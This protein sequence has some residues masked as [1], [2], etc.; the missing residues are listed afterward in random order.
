MVRHVL[1]RIRIAVEQVAN[2]ERV[3]VR[4]GIDDGDGEL[5]GETFVPVR[6][7]EGKDH[8]VAV[9]FRFP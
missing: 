9:R 3:V 5:A 2:R 1:N 6:T 4:E 7:R 8:G